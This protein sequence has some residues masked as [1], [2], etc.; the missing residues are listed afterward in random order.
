MPISKQQTDEALKLQKKL[1]KNL[2]S[3][4]GVNGISVS[5]MPGAHEQICVKV[6]VDN[7]KLTTKSLGIKDSYN[8]IPVILSK[9]DISPI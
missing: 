7:D 3:K 6:I 8:N 4:K 5:T 1:E 2:M 9:E